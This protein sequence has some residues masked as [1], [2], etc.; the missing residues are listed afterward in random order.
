MSDLLFELGSEELPARFVNPAARELRERVVEALDG[1]RLFHGAAR[2]YGTPRRIAVLVE[3]VAERQ[4]D[5]ER[6]AV[7]P[8]A[9]AA[10]DAA[11]QPTKAAEGFA[12]GQ[13]VG[14]SALVRVQTPRGEYVAVRVREPGRPAAEVLPGLLE[15]AMRKITF[16]K[17]M[18]WGAVEVTW[19]RP[20][21]W[22]CALYGRTLLPVRY[23]DVASGGATRGH[24]FLDPAPVAL[25]EPASYAARLREAHVLAAFDE[26]RARVLALAEEAAA[27]TGGVL[28]RD[29]SLLDQVANLVEWP[30]AIAGGFDPGNLTLPREVLLSEMN[31]HQ[32]YFAVAGVDG[33]LRPAFVAVSATPVMDP[34]VA[35]HG[36]ERVLRARLADARFFF[37]EDRKVPLESR[38]E[39]LGAVVFQQKLGTSLEKV[40]RI[41]QIAGW[42]AAAVKLPP[43]AAA[44]VQR[45][46]RLCKAD[47]TTGMVGEFPE[48]QGVMGREY[49]RASGEPPEVAAAIEEHYLPRF[50]GDRLPAFVAVS[51]TPVKDPKVSRHGYERVLRARL[52]DAR[53]FFDED[54]KASLDSRV[55]ALGR[56]VFQ[57]KLGTSLEK[58]ERFSALAQWLCSALKLPAAEA[59]TI[60]RAARLCKADLTTGMVG[61]FPELQGV[62]GREYARASGETE[63]V[64]RA[65]EEHYLPRFSG[66]RLPS[67]DAGALVGIADRIDTL[68]GLFG[69]GKPPTG[70]ADP[71][72]LRRACLG[73]IHVTLARGYRYSLSGALDRALELVASKLTVPAA[74]AKPQLLDFFRRRLEALWTA[75]AEGRG[76][77]P[78]VFAPDLVEAV[79][80]AGFDDLWAARRRLEAVAA[81]RSSPDFL[82]LASAFKRAVN[83]LEKSSGKEPLGPEGRGFLDQVDHD[84]LAEEPERA[85]YKAALVARQRSEQALGKDDFAEAL[86]AATAMKPAIDL[87]FDKVLV[88]ADDREVRAN[89]LRLLAAVRE[90]FGRVADLSKIQAEAAK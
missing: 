51:A 54:R 26:R 77:R 56:I 23:G 34:A 29:D 31:G 88:M 82:P 63:E 62:M 25:D 83:I 71:F 19:A 11:G 60:A 13:G 48:L 21:Q 52:A 42:L 73:V 33:S 78:D 38:V 72:A 7:G 90:I 61:E 9:R 24:R 76:N 45:A 75:E 12:R 28:V 27:K 3:G 67:A 43:E 4:A 64:A 89:R 65:I 84:R 39:A 5:L 20:L 14:V 22:I 57:Q 35:R 46:A 15:S 36:Y 59:T 6:E 41:G 2:E 87:F 8:A 80:S 37:D 55:E 32:R 58:V 50:F 79:L 70:A 85:L 53:F 17:A 10:F 86:R 16:P 1:A 69:I 47:L 49:A 74:Q 18:R 66:D 30:V 40:E 44:T 68:A 81:I